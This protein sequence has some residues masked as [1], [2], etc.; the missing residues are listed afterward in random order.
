MSERS[1][2]PTAKRR[3]EAREQ[4]RVVASSQVVSAIVWL[5]IS[6]LLYSQSEYIASLLI[7]QSKSVW[8]KPQGAD[9]LGQWMHACLTFAGL[10]TMPV[11][12]FVLLLAV[13]ARIAQ[14]GFLWAPQRVGFDANRLNPAS[15]FQSMLG[16]DRWLEVLRGGVV[17]ACALLL[18]GGGIWFQRYELM[19]LLV[20]TDFE[21]SAIRLLASW[22]LKLGGCL[23]VFAAMD[24]A[25]Q[26][27]RFEQ[28]L[29]MTPD[30]VR[31]EV[32]AIEG[33]PAVATGRKRLRHELATLGDARPD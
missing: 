7:D 17:V 28:S 3:K 29:L 31:A 27:Y 8:A 4:G 9:Q 15:R 11:I 19:Q 5:A 16:M 23:A 2:Q 22:A 13:L 20:Q 14:T 24:Y 12:G 1:L 18:V 25:I 21:V 10:L 6:A 33:N 30:E 26:R 32:K